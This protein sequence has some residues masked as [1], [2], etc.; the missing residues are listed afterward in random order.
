NKILVVNH[1]HSHVCG[2]HDLGLRIVHRL[3]TSR[4][5]DVS[6]VEANDWLTSLQTY[7]TVWPDV[8]LIN[9]RPDLMSWVA[10]RLRDI[11][12]IKIAVMHNYEVVSASHVALGL[13]SLGFDFA[14]AFDPTLHVKGHRILTT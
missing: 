4:E 12:G 11:N 14:M 10:P 7:E 3:A 8:V 5:I 2:I 6:Y 1:A 9:Y 13:T